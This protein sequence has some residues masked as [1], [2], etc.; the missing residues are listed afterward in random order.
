MKESFTGRELEQKL[1]TWGFKRPLEA[2][3][4]I[5]RV[6]EEDFVVTAVRGISRTMHV[7]GE[8]FIMQRAR[9]DSIGLTGHRDFYV[10]GI[11]RGRPVR[12]YFIGKYEGSL[13]KV[14]IE[15]K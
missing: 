6:D 4:F 9:P 11:Y 10:E 1:K 12:A 3:G 2:A 15:N 14:L 7:D 13:W 8:P 5:I